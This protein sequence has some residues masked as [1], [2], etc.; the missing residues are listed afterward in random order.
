[1]E[2]GLSYWAGIQYPDGSFDEAYPYERSLAA[3]SFTTFYLTEAYAHVSSAVAPATR[4]TFLRT[5]RH[6]ADWLCE[7]DER[8]GV[9]SNHLAAAAAALWN[10]GELTGDPRHQERARTFLARILAKQSSDGFYEEY[11]GADIGYQTHGS[12]YL[13]RIWQKNGDERLLQSLRAANAFLKHF[14]HP[15]GSLGGM[16]GSRNTTFYFP[17]A[18]E[19]LAAVCPSAAAI[20]GQ[21][22][23]RVAAGRTVGLEQMDAPNLMP[24]LNN[25]LF[26]HAALARAAPPAA[27]PLPWTMPG[28]WDFPHAGLVVRRGLGYYAV[29]GTSKGGTIQ[30]WDT[31]ARAL[32]FQS[33]GYVVERE[34]VRSSNQALGLAARTGHGDELAIDA[35]FVQINQR[36]FNPW[37]FLGFRGFSLTLG[38]LRTLAYWLKSLLVRVLVSRRRRAALRLE[39]TIRF[40]DGGFT[41]EDRVFP[42]DA[43]VTHLDAFATIHMGSS[44]YADPDHLQR[45]GR[46]EAAVS[47]TF[48]ER[49]VLTRAEVS[50]P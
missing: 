12:F 2:A 8:H 3:V 5:V 9:L 31:R 45:R 47:R 24:M 50:L 27:E 6:A 34:G 32:V 33:G 38:R 36:V 10:A 18:Y 48:D 22:R 16:Y 39:R 26:A 14:I 25:Y 40:R 13:A 1:V 46:E 4:E 23:E 43:R 11:G 35:P 41:L 49:G 30:A 21:Q 17:A 42:P 44:R 28:R 20:A 37:L 7:N 15:D 19:M 29:V